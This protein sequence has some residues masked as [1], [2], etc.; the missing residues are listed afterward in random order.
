[1][2]EYYFQTRV[3]LQRQVKTSIK[4]REGLGDSTVLLVRVEGER[5]KRKKEKRD[6][7]L[8]LVPSGLNLDE[9]RE[10]Q[11]IRGRQ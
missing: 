10:L 4:G 1:M 7:G 6:S 9:S 3:S 11:R 2:S 8:G 5:G